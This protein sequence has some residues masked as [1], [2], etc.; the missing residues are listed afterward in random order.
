MRGLLGLSTQYH[1]LGSS[2]QLGQR[3]SMPFKISPLL[4]VRSSCYTHSV[5]AQLTFVAVSNVTL[6]AVVD[7]FS[8]HL[9]CETA[10]LHLI[11]VRPYVPFAPLFHS[12]GTFNTKIS[13]SDCTVAEFNINSPTIFD[14][15]TP[16]NGTIT[17]DWGYGQLSTCVEDS[18]P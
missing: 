13:S 8:A 16:Y 17:Y 9:D 2:T 18:S 14:A 5:D 3:H 11:G 4:M 7:V 6:E 15:N 12:G 10:N 1:D